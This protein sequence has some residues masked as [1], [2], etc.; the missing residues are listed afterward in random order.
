MQPKPSPICKLKKNIYIYKQG[1]NC[2]KYI[3]ALARPS[4]YYSKIVLT[5]LFISMTHNIDYIIDNSLSHCV[6]IN[7][8]AG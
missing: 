3:L 5:K 6:V 4:I 2:G 7:Q 1:T 8:C